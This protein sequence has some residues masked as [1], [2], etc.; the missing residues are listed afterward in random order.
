LVDEFLSEKEQIDQIRE[1]WRENGWYLIGGVALGV[2]VLL[3]WNRYNAYQDAQAEA[4]AAL[5]VELRQAAA[6]DAPG[7]AR[8]LLAQLREN[9]PSSPYSDHGGLLVAIIRMEAGQM[10]GAMDELRQVMEGTSDPELGLIARLRLA[11]VLA[12]EEMYDEALATLDV[13]AG[14]FSGRYNEVRGDVYVALGDPV[15]AQAAYN[16]ALTAQESNLVDRNL[17]QMKLEDLP[18]AEATTTEEVTQ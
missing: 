9:Y 4:A 8:N 15:N 7:D 3:G 11:R 12:N 6:D 10:N 1:W 14:S 16:A 13:D 2:I 18:A 17:V 5:Y